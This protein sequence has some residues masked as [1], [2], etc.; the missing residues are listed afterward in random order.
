MHDWDYLSQVERI[1]EEDDVFSSVIAQRNVFEFAID[2]RLALEVGSGL[3]ER[4]LT[5][6]QHL[7]VT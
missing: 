4:E 5:T 7:W 6:A 2:D 1:E 3:G